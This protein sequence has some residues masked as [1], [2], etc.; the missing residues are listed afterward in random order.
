MPIALRRRVRLVRGVLPRDAQAKGNTLTLLT[1]LGFEIRPAK[2]H[3]ERILVG[4]HLGMIID[5]K[6]G[7]FLARTAKLKQI[8][9]M[10][11][12]LL[13]RAACHKRLFNVKNGKAKIVARG[14]PRC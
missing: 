14:N 4:E 3:F 5:M 13:Y 7:R 11:K 6:E 12:T 10:V 9:V 1:R 8:T 2:E